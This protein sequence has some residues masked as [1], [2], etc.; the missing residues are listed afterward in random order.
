MQYKHVSTRGQVG[1]L[2]EPFQNRP[3]TFDGRISGPI[4]TVHWIGWAVPLSIIHS[5]LYSH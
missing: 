2:I 4:G 3:A 5:H 1:G